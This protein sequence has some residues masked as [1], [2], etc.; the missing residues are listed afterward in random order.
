MARLVWP[1]AKFAFAVTFRLLELFS[2]FHSFSVS[3]SLGSFLS[4]SSSSSSSSSSSA[5]LRFLLEVGLMSAK[6]ESGKQQ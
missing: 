1:Y 2:H 4:G 3:R 6:K 5:L